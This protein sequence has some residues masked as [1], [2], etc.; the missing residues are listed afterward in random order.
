MKI[1]RLKERIHQIHAQSISWVPLRQP[2]DQQ[3]G[4]KMVEWIWNVHGNLAKFTEA[5]LPLGG[6]HATASDPLALRFV[7][8]EFRTSPKISLLDLY[9]CEFVFRALKLSG[10]VPEITPYTP[11]NPQAI[12]TLDCFAPPVLLRERRV[13]KP[14]VIVRLR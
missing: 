12:V 7:H 11:M 14:F 9:A 1:F 2:L 10:R 8:R 3:S 4:Q 6:T 5:S 13:K